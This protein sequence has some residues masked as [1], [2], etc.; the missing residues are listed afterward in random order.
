MRVPG[1]M[2]EWL[3]TYLPILVVPVSSMDTAAISVG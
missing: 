1:M 2:N 3:K